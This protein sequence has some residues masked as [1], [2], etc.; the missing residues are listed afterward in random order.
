MKYMG[1]KRLML[2][3]GLGDVLAGL[4][5]KGTRFVDLFSGSGVV[6]WHVA[7][8]YR[9]PTVAID[10]QLYSKIL[11]NSVLARTTTVDSSRL[12]TR[13]LANARSAKRP[14][15]WPEGSGLTKESLADMRTWCEDRTA[16]PVLSAY[17]GH[18]FHPE[19]ASWI[20]RL[21]M[22][23]PDREPYRTVAL[24]AL[25]SAAS[26]VAAS[27][28]HTAQ[29]LRLKRSSKGYIEAAWA[30]EVPKVVEAVLKRICMA[31]ALVRGY[32]VVQDAKEFALRLV[33][34]DIVFID[35]PY[36][37]VQYSRFYHVLE[38]I[39]AGGPVVVDG[40]GRYP[41]KELRPQSEFCTKRTSAAALRE[42]LSRV[43]V[44]GAIAVL[45]F[46]DSECSNGLSGDLVRSIAGEFF[47]MD[48]RYVNSHFSSLGGRKIPTDKAMK[49]APRRSVREMILVLDAR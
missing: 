10:L 18:Y 49:R 5:E 14:R 35:P 33:Q 26:M 19:Q 11:A 43:S 28:G 20:D 47:H 29:P 25:V 8:K 15:H 2:E 34:N 40:A 21:R 32:A 6:S 30:R 24:A 23:L 9:I 42:L 41:Q 13:W 31:H 39:A 38:T 48:V 22:T 7:A 17:G 45:T 16:W 27:P 44:H 1:S 46:P 4:C 37:A 3:N 36:A 12:W